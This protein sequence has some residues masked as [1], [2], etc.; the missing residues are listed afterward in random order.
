MAVDTRNKR[1]SV[2][3][4]TSP[5]LPALPNPDGTLDIGDRPILL[6]LYA[7]FSLTGGSAFDYEYSLASG[8]HP[9]KS[10]SHTKALVIPNYVTVSSPEGEETIYT[11]SASHPDSAIL[12]FRHSV[13]LKVTSNTQATSI[14]NAILSH[15]VIEAEKGAVLVPMNIGQEI[16]DYIKTTDSRA[17][18]FRIGNVGYIRRHYKGG[19]FDMEGRFGSAMFSGALGP[20]LVSSPGSEANTIIADAIRDIF[21]ILERRSYVA[22][23][24]I[25]DGGGAAITTGSKGYLKIPFTC[26]INAWGIY[27]DQEGS[28]V[29]DVK[30]HRF[31]TFPSGTSI[32]GTEKPTL[33]SAQGNQDFSLTSWTTKILVP[34]NI[35][36]FVVDSVTDVKR[37]TIMHRE[38]RTYMTTIY[39]Q[40]INS[41]AAIICYSPN[42]KAQTFTP[43]VTHTITHAEIRAYRSGSPGTITI[44]IRATDGS[45]HPTG[46]DLC[47]VTFNGNTLPASY[48][49]IYWMT[50]FFEPG[51]I[52]QASTKY[53]IV[54]RHTGDDSNKALLRYD[55][56]G[57]YANGN[58]EESS[59]SGSTWTS[60]TDKD[61]HFRERGDPPPSPSSYS[62]G[63]IIG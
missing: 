18:D 19:T 4:L 13:E 46:A 49:P 25:I 7:G 21:S 56:S 24:F 37:V 34:N 28:I 5:T 45:G 17:G 59:D 32:A 16:Y 57:T 2:I 35:L 53:A 9:F 38:K 41:D 14:A 48:N 29:V 55:S 63:Q 58:Y 8:E 23:E 62:Q 31:A 11:G 43:Q 40:Y 51:C 52:L 10:K 61:F 3:G 26:F 1:F 36:E 44:S 20:L 33:S 42:W 60:D 50:A 6:M 15:A 22:I 27:A 47:S 30:T 39:N 54:W 12:E